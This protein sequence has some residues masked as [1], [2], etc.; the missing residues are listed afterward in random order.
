MRIW[1]VSFAVLAGWAVMG[2]A[3]PVD[4]KEIPSDAK[5]V[6]HVDVDA[7]REGTLVG[8]AYDRVVREHPQIED[9][10]GAVERF[11][12]MDPRR[13]LHSLTFYDTRLVPDKGVL[14]V[15]ADVDKQRLL[16]KAEDAPG[17]KV[18]EHGEYQIH[19]WIHD[20]G[21]KR[22]RNVS[23]TFFT[24]GVL[25]FGSS[26]EDV[27][28]AID[29]LAGKKKSLADR[30]S[31]LAA[32]VPPGTMFL[33]RVVG[34]TGAKLPAKSP[35]LKKIEQVGVALGEHE[36]QGFLQASLVAENQQTAEEIRTVVEGVRAMVML[37]HGEDP[38][39]KA[40]MKGLVLEVSDKEVS[41]RLQASVDHI[42]RAA[43]KAEAEVKKHHK[44]YVDKKR[45]GESKDQ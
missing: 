13:D 9:H 16:E 25:V 3:G 37:Q 34:L 21:K 35:V 4:F 7:M 44:E 41:V 30:E 8:R 42:W 5:W 1:A 32:K 17:H 19:T 18:T 10:F 15:R 14:I 2:Q 20:E 26:V 27:K 6:A 38:D 45:K 22:E 23:G 31:P 36:G 24:P 33:A 43:E 11:S 28:K 29:V 40:L 39:A 12:G